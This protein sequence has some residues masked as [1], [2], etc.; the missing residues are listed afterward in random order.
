MR[1]RTNWVESSRH[2]GAD[3]SEGC[4]LDHGWMKDRL[5][6]ED[7]WCG[8]VVGQV[9]CGWWTHIALCGTWVEFLGERFM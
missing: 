8:R 6:G 2:R 3:V 5:G 9:R 4:E 7:D 1:T